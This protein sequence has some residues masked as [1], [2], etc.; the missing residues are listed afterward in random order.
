[1]KRL[2]R[3]LLGHETGEWSGWLSY[4]RAKF[5]RTRFCSRCKTELVER[6]G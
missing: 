3:R 2:T 4:G 5:Y 6:D 1:V